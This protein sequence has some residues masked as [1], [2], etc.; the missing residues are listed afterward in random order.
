MTEFNVFYSA[1]TNAF[2]PTDLRERYEQAGTWPGDVVGITD[3]M[4]NTFSVSPPA[5]KIRIA[6]RDKLPAWG[7]APPPTHDEQIAA[8]E[9]HRAGLLAHA[10]IITADW[11]TELALGEINDDDRAKLSAW[12]AY[13]K[14]VKTAKAED[15]LA[16]GFKWPTLPAE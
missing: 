1:G 3:E 12:M 6:G 10:D 11:R 13:K 14:A 2:Y 16:A 15:A 4:F 7:D 5:G 9:Q 8:V